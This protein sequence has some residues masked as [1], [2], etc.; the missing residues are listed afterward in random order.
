MLQCCSWH[1]DYSR[2]RGRGTWQDML[3]SPFMWLISLSY[4]LV[5]L[6][7]TATLDWAQLYLV[8]DL[9]HSQYLGLSVVTAYSNK[10]NRVHY[11]QDAAKRQTASIKFTHRPKISLRQFIWNLA[12]PKGK[13]VRLPM[14]NFTP[15]CARGWECSPKMAKIFTFW[16]R[17]APQGRT[18]WPISSIL[19]GFYVPNFTLCFKIDMIHITG[20]DVIAEKPRQLFIPKFS[21]HPV[22]KT[23]RWIEKWF[24]LF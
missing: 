11:R 24:H 15:I 7:R 1:A 23:R 22:G 5:F 18:L 20:Y 21:V 17:V 9:G 10:Q 8:Q 14:Q 4:F 16:L 19:R 6:G 2:G 13:W 3:R 12:Q